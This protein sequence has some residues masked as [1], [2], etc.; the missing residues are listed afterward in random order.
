[1]VQYLCLVIFLISVIEVDQN[2]FFTKDRTTVLLNS[3]FLV[4]G[5]VKSPGSYS[6][7]LVTIK[8]TL[9]AHIVKPINLVRVATY[10]TR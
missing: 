5:N 10:A 9:F 2:T 1:M 7:E 8:V 3:D 4:A 6:P